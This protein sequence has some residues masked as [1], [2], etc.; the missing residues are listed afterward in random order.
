[1]PPN[2]TPNDEPLDPAR[3]AIAQQLRELDQQLQPYDELVECRARLTSALAALDGGTATKKRVRR[4][5]VAA[6]LAIHP[7]SMPA[8]IAAAFEVPRANVQAHLVR[9]EGTLFENNNGWHV[10]D[11]WE[12][13]DRGGDSR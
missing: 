1:V 4:H 12:D 2:P 13:A 7:G 10:L 6:Y 5:D 8:E 3:A 9:N 11:G